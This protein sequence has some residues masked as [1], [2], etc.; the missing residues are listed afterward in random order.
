MPDSEQQAVEQRRKGLS[1][2]LLFQSGKGRY[3]TRPANPGPTTATTTPP[4]APAAPI[5]RAAVPHPAA[6]PVPAVSETVKQGAPHSATSSGQDASAEPEPAQTERAAIKVAATPAQLL[7]S[8]REGEKRFSLPQRSELTLSASAAKALTRVFA[9]LAL[10][11]GSG[12]EVDQSQKTETLQAI[13]SAAHTTANS[14]CRLIVTDGRLSVPLHLRAKLLQSCTEYF[15]RQWAETGALDAQPLI[16]LAEQAFQAKVDGLTDEVAALFHEANE[17][18]PASTEQINQARITDAALRASFRCLAVVTSFDLRHYDEASA[19]AS[20]APEPFSYGQPPAMVVR[21]LTRII[22]DISR[23]SQLDIDDP[24]L[25]TMWTQNTIERAAMLVCAEYRM[26][27]DRALRASFN[28]NLLSQ[29]ALADV[30]NRYPTLMSHVAK[31]ALEAYLTAERNAVD[32]MAASAYKHYLPKKAAPDPEP[33]AQDLP[34]T[35][36]TPP[37]NPISETPAAAA[38]PAPRIATPRKG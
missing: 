11:P 34:Q 2:K 24:D 9:A 22:L 30:S 28:D 17:Y 33:H 10:E 1:A 27:T 32:C 37:G 23:Q 25:S 36:T 4:V 8:Q 26:I 5:P 16:D 7:D 19:D 6:T 18:Q 3:F 14:L 12:P 15:T 13:I 20:G 35:A 38:R 31:R 29:A 21:D